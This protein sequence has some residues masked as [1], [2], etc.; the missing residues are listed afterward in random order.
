[1]AVPRGYTNIRAK[2]RVKAKPE[3]M[4]RIR[5]L[6]SFSPVFNTLTSGTNVEVDVALK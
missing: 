3:D 6:A 4:S 5:E 1:M 2:F